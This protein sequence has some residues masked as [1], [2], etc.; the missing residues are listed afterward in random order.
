M[1]ATTVFNKEENS[2]YIYL[3]YTLSVVLSAL[4]ASS[5][6]IGSLSR[7][8]TSLL[9]AR[10]IFVHAIGILNFQRDMHKMDSSLTTRCYSCN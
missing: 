5:N 10:S 2:S 8:M 7:T 4:G 1:T 6:L 9:A 3:Y